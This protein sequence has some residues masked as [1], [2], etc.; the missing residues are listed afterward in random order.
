MSWAYQFE[1]EAL[2]ELKALDREVQRRIVRYL[3]T[4]IAGNASPRRFGHAL[5]GNLHG[6][7]R[8]RVGDHRIVGR[9]VESVVLVSIVRVGHR[10]DVYDI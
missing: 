3:D 9:I 6:L 1:A 10:K 7:W 8:W 5:G 2:R 4:R